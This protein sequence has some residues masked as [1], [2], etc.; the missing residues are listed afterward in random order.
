MT[1]NYDLALS[2]LAITIYKLSRNDLPTIKELAEEFNVSIRTIQRDISQRLVYFPIEKDSLG[3]LKFI[4]GYSLSK[5][6]LENDEL[7]VTY[8]ALSQL[9]NI[10][11]EFDHN[12]DNVIN[13]IFY[14]GYNSV[15]HIKPEPFEK[16]DSDSN[17]ILTL[18]EAIEKKFLCEI[19]VSDNYILIEPQKIISLDGI[20]YLL[21]L[22]KSENKI[23]SFLLSKIENVKLTT[24]RFKTNNSIEKTIENVH[25][26]FFE[27]GNSFKVIIKI[28]PEVSHFFKIKSFLPS[29]EI[30]EEFEDS[31]LMVS[32]HVTHYEDID[33]IIK[34]WLPHIEVL[35]PIEYKEQIIEE[36]KTYLDKI[37][38]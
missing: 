12:I 4:D 25:S 9:K 17:N 35:E 19:K 11:K 27:D 29:Q 34:S 5:S 3:R 16:L 36:L 30:L 15:F 22:E 13:K 38:K 24:K 28:S 8:L 37:N 31:S 23:K 1:K 7:L 6:T 2:R 32:F 20:W 18:E 14:P 21:A 26:G 33:N 10:N